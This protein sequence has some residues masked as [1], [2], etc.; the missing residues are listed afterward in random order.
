MKM[1][2]Q[3]VDWTVAQ[4][5][6]VYGEPEQN[7]RPKPM[8]NLISTILSQNTSD[9][10]SRRAY[11]SLREH[12]PT[13]EDVYAAKPEAVAGAIRS[14]GLAN[15]KSQRIKRVLEYVRT[16]NGSFDLEWICGEDPY[17]IID[18]FTGI[19][20]IGVKT[21]SIVLCFSCHQNVFP[22]DTH[23]NRICQRLGFVPEKSAPKKTFWTMEEYIPDGKARTFHL[24]VIHHGRTICK[25]KN[26]QCSECVLLTKCDYGQ[27]SINNG[28]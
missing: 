12:F 25:S 18:E 19:K 28:N 15:Q 3:N 16:N 27:N 1:T 13:W 17:D 23:V 22:V 10:N 11:K 20:G 4:L 24:N 2:Q 9:V 26:P 7:T 5:E 21:I 14:G 8:D 6:S